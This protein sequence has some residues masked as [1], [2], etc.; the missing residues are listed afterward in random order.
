M[1]VLCFA[2]DDG[3]INMFC[4]RHDVLVLSKGLGGGCNNDDGSDLEEGEFPMLEAA[5]SSRTATR[6]RDR[7][8]LW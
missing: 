6:L 1:V 2:G 4:A 8:R 7:Q 3:R 5:V